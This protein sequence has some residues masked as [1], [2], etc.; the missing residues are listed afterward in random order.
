[1]TIG[2]QQFLVISLQFCIATAKGAL[3]QRISRD[4]LSTPRA[5]GSWW[6]FFQR[7][8]ASE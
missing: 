6:G 1:M 7:K 3:M 5:F 4:H 2:L 8:I